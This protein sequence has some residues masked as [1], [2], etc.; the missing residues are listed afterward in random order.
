M[1]NGRFCLLHANMRNPCAY[2]YIYIVN[3]FYYRHCSVCGSKVHTSVH[4]ASSAEDE[5]VFTA[6][7]QPVLM[8]LLKY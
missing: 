4:D 2:I 7:A 5:T 6:A 1:E 3:E 8:L